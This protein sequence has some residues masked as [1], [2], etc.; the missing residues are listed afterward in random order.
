MQ[1]IVLCLSAA[2]VGVIMTGCASLIDGGKTSVTISTNAP[3]AT[4]IVRKSINGLVVSSGKAP[5]TVSLKTANDILKPATYMCDVIDPKKKKQSRVLETSFNPLFLGNFIFGN[6][7]G[8]AIDVFS[9]SCYRFEKEL[10]IHFSE[11]DSA[12]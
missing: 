12:N 1:K 9:G 6:F 7:I 2:F 8:M 4:V 10:Y 11:Y 3:D 5:L